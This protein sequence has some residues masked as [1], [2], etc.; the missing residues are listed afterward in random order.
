MMAGR[1]MKWPNEVLAAVHNNQPMETCL[2]RDEV[3]NFL[4][5]ATGRG[6]AAS[7]VEHRRAIRA[8]APN[9][10]RIFVDWR[11]DV[12]YIEV[13]PSGHRPDWKRNETEARLAGASL[14]EAA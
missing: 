7:V 6:Y 11:W 8:R 9:G 4:L 2:R 14:E 1:S 13:V 12:A 5:R 10:A 3:L